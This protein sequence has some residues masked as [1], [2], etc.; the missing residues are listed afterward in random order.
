V[1]RLISR[2]LQAAARALRAL[3]A[4]VE[5]SDALWGHPFGDYRRRAGCRRNGG[6]LRRDGAALVLGIAVEPAVPSNRLLMV[7]VSVTFATLVLLARVFLS[8]A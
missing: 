3:A 6:T 5:Q 1:A 7:V 4:V 2:A 8:H